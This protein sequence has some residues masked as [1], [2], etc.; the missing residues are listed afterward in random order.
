MSVR[1][2]IADHAAWS[3]DDAWG[4]KIEGDSDQIERCLPGELRQ[5]H[6][7]VVERARLVDSNALILSGSTVRRMRTEISDLDYPSSVRRSRQAIC[8]ASWMSTSCLRKNSSRSCWAAM[9]SSSGR[10]G[11]G[12]WCSTTARFGPPFG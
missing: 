5:L 2:V 3:T 4:R 1:D 7:A 6:D 11:S 8:P 9:T 10:L 12:A